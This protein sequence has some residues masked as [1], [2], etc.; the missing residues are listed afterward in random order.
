MLETFAEICRAAAF[1]FYDRG[2]DWDRVGFHWEGVWSSELKVIAERGG[3]WG[4]AVRAVADGAW[5]AYSQSAKVRAIALRKVSDLASKPDDLYRLGYYC[6]RAARTEYLGVDLAVEQFTDEQLEL[7]HQADRR[8]RDIR[9]L[10]CDLPRAFLGGDPRENILD[11]AIRCVEDRDDHP[12]RVQD[13]ADS[14]WVLES[15]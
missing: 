14:S 8:V 1:D 13:A 4:D 15:R 3:S 11:R 10:H 9:E 2:L 12:S 5:P 6:A 7:R